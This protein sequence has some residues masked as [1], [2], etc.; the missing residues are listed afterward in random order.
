MAQG[1]RTFAPRT[2]VDYDTASRQHAEYCRQ[3]EECGANVRTL[4][5][6][7][8]L[9]DCTFVEDTAIILDEVA[10]LASMG[11]A[12]RCAEPAGIEPELSRYREVCRIEPPA[13]IEGGDVLRVDRTLFVGL[14][15]RTNRSGIRELAA[16]VE[17]FG[18]RVV[19]VSVRGCL[20]LKTACTA[21]PDNRLLVNPS[22]LEVRALRSL[23]VLPVPE[24]E[25]WAA[26]VAI[27]GGTVIMAAGNVRT[28]E[29]VRELEFDVRTV[30]IAEFSKA[31]G[32]VT[33][34]SLIL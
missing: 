2:G 32:G 21:L 16:V 7:R 12:S 4:T 28:A 29:L 20:H 31:E 33:C 18:Y 30:D 25:P 27:I 3:L 1:E 5:I 11:T 15:P 26:N 22:W 6:N 14:S 9:P 13:T 10:V 23:R 17:R 19:P 24:P 34:L 8:E